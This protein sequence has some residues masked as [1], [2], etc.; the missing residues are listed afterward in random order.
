VAKIILVKIIVE[1][2]KHLSDNR[3][4]YVGFWNWGSYTGVDVNAYVKFWNL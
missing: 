1:R 2:L 3:C 4:M